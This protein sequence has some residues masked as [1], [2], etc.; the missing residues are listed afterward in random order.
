M[1]DFKTAQ[2]NAN[3]QKKNII[4]ST[5]IFVMLSNLLIQIW[6]LYTALNNALDGHK[7]VA[8]ST[9]IASFVLFLASVIWL[10]LLPEDDR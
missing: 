9:F 1:S 4:L 7:E 2:K 6:L 3:P 10:Y 5:L 8:I